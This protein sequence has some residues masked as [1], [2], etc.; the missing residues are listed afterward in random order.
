MLL[1]D[2]R[3]RSQLI[4]K[5]T[6]VEKPRFPVIDAHNHL[7]E[8]FGGGWINRP[9]DEILAT[10]EQAGVVGYVDLDGGWG[11]EIFDLHLSRLC[12][13]AEQF[14]L[15]A[16][17]DWAKWPQLGDAFPAYAVDRLYA[18]K[19]RGAFGLKIWKPFGLH[20]RDQHATMLHLLGMDHERFS[21]KVMGL[22]ARLTGV[23][24]ANVIKSLLA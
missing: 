17:V 14:R 16:G 9:L 7:G 11:E 24:K 6:F 15:F 20:V 21:F 22:D 8:A 3:P 4:V 23:D 12:P 2:Y 5:T 18:Q 13:A 10:M 19:E 1:E